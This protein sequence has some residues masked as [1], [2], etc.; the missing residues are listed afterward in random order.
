MSTPRVMCRVQALYPYQSA[1]PSSL[2]FGKGDIIEVLTQLESGWWDG[3]YV[4][5]FLLHRTQSRFISLAGT[6]LC[7][8]IDYP[9]FSYA[10]YIYT[11]LKNM[12]WEAPL[13]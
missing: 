6:C 8:W 13:E 12:R 9:V 2:S 3:W 11:L 5:S 4:S 7:H 1:D 10:L